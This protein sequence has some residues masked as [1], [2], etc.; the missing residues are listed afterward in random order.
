MSGRQKATSGEMSIIVHLR[1]TDAD[2]RAYMSQ[3]I[4]LGPTPSKEDVIAPLAYEPA[5]QTLSESFAPWGGERQAEK[6][7][8]NVCSVN[9][10]S[11]APVEAKTEPPAAGESKF[12]VLDAM[13]EFADANRRKEWPRSTSVWCRWCCDSFQGP[14][15]ALPKWRMQETFYVSGCY[16]S[17]SCAAAHLWFRGDMSIENKWE[18]FALLHL[19]RKKILGIDETQRIVS[20][21][22]QDILQKFGGY[23]SVQEFRE[24]TKE[25]H[26][27]HKMFKVLFPPMISVVPKIEENNFV[28]ELGGGPRSAYGQMKYVAPKN[29]NYH[30]RVRLGRDQP[31]LPVDQDKLRKA[32]ENLKIKRDKPLLNKK[33]TLLN[34]MDL[35]INHQANN[36][37]A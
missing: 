14:P 13:C 36:D 26:L 11:A 5:G 34:Y 15:V 20:A 3:K 23:L 10:D 4:D 17:Y 16:C 32:Q 28:E 25:T 31:F 29:E 9:L 33:H 8:L 27:H 30:A 35:Q 22:A 19:L 21:P 18:S 37:P 1:I 7:D 6:Y 12:R 2:V 24:L